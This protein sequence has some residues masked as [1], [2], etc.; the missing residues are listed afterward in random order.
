MFTDTSSAPK[1]MIEGISY[2]QPLSFYV[3]ADSTAP[4]GFHRTV[5]EINYEF[6]YLTYAAA[7]SIAAAKQALSS[8][9]TD[10]Y[11]V[12]ARWVRSYDD[13]GYN[14]KVNEKRKTGWTPDT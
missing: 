10:S 9:F 5:S 7:D 14:V 12:T 6:R 13:G 3:L 8:P 11:I 2:R 1:I 4:T